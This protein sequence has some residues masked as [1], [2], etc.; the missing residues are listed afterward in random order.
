MY[1]LDCKYDRERKKRGK[2][3]LANA[4]K[5]NCAASSED[6]DRTDGSSA[7]IT[8]V[9]TKTSPASSPCTFHLSI[10]P[11]HLFN[12]GIPEEKDRFSTDFPSSLR[13]PQH[14]VPQNDYSCKIEPGTTRGSFSSVFMD[15]SSRD[16]QSVDTTPSPCYQT[17]EPTCYASQLWNRVYDTF[18]QPRA[19][20]SPD[21]V[22]TP[23]NYQI[24]PY[25]P[26][27]AGCQC[28][29]SVRLYPGSVIWL[30]SPPPPHYAPTKYGT[31]LSEEET[32]CFA[33]QDRA[34]KDS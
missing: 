18:E 27:C 16:V 24:L 25:M 31:I 30:P 12:G 21:I 2:G 8:P 23:E 15:G 22:S 4:S 6:F 33:E 11:S 17:P 14:A 13:P 7:P 19:L 29:S 5:G 26:L 20:S 32:Y 28:N 3:S 10:P 9:T 34:G 1:A